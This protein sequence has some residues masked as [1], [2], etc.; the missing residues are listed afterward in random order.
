MSI[1]IEVWVWLPGGDCGIVEGTVTESGGSCTPLCK[2]EVCI[3]AVFGGR[4]LTTWGCCCCCCALVWVKKGYGGSCCS[5][6]R[7]SIATALTEKRQRKIAGAQTLFKRT[8]SSILG[9]KSFPAVFC[10]KRKWVLYCTCT[11]L[12][13]REVQIMAG[14]GCSAPCLSGACW[15]WNWGSVQLMKLPC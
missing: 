11:P 14:I 6:E 5:R 10:H 12:R 1:P 15:E 13:H 7:A 2:P 9:D 8:K 4:E 3:R